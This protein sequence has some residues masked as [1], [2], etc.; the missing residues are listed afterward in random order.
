MIDLA[1]YHKEENAQALEIKTLKNE[2]ELLIKF[3]ERETK[4]LKK[5]R[6]A[7]VRLN[8]S[9]LNKIDK[10]KSERRAIYLLGQGLSCNKIATLVKTPLSRILVIKKEL[11]GEIN[12]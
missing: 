6:S 9:S 10:L 12:E 8:E 4:A 1:R 11:E 5:E 3:V 7:L 2:Y